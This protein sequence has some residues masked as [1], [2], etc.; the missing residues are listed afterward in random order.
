MAT[1]LNIYTLSSRLVNTFSKHC[2][3]GLNSIKKTMQ[4]YHS[5]YYYSYEYCSFI[6]FSTTKLGKQ[7]CGQPWTQ[8]LENLFIE[9]A[10]QHNPIVF[11]EDYMFVGSLDYDLKEEI[12]L[13]SSFHQKIRKL[14]K[15]AK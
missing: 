10:V 5:F 15:W 1:L 3:K 2:T 6:P 12:I 4:E 8:D 14:H 7:Q 9:N 11:Y 13:A